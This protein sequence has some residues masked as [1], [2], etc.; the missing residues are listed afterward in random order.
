MKRSRKLP[1]PPASQ[2]L[3]SRS[4]SMM[5]PGVTSAGAIERAIRKRSGA[6]GCRIETCPKPSTTPCAARMRLA[7]AR[8]RSS[9]AS[10][11]PADFGVSITASDHYLGHDA[12][13]ED[14]LRLELAVGNA[15]LPSI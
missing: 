4:Y 9:S 15:L 11:A 5:S 1:R 12:L 6:A 14:L 7:A 13:R 3:Q 8:S 10:T 2:G